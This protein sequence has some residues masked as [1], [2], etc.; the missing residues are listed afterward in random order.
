MQRVHPAFP[1]VHVTLE[2]VIAENDPVAVRATGRGTL[3]GPRFGHA[4]SR[5]LERTW[6]D[7]E[8]R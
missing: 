8:F 4:Q 6:P 5:R 3:N 7:A 2:D 1:D